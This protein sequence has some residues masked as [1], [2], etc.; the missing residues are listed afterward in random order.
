M[1][2]LNEINKGGTFTQFQGLQ[3]NQMQ[4]IS[5]FRNLQNLLIKFTVK[6][7]SEKAWLLYE[8]PFSS[9]PGDNQM[10]HRHERTI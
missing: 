2:V 4:N 10:L 8:F 9:K 1:N 6:D 5:K 3:E 7:S